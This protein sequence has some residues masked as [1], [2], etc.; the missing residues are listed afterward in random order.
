MGTIKLT[1]RKSPADY[2]DGYQA[3]LVW[4]EGMVTME[5]RTGSA[6]FVSIQQRIE[7]QIEMIKA[8][9]KAEAVFKEKLNHD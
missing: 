1:E 6:S 3:A 9:R 8:V 4:A 2:I 5:F 7:R